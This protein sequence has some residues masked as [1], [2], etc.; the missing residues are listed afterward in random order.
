MAIEAIVTDKAPAALGPYSAGAAAQGFSRV[1]HV[2]GQLPIDPATGEFAG[3]DIQAQTRQS[4]T[5]V[6]SILEAAGASMTD[7]AEVTVLLD[8]ID[9]FA[10]MNEVY[11][12][13]FEVPYP[14]RAAFEVAA[15]PKG[16]KIEIKAVAYV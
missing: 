3:D 5:N 4:L 6:R 12:E 11:A 2:S 7:V 8:D 16:A 10:A 1:I 14:S 9:D 13:F 15:I